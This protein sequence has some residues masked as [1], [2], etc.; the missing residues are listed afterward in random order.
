MTEKI[1][2]IMYKKEVK[3]IRLNAEELVAELKKYHSQG[4]KISAENNDIRFIDFDD[5]QENLGQLAGNPCI[6]IDDVTI[7]FHDELSYIYKHPKENNNL[8]MDTLNKIYLYINS[9]KSI[10]KYLFKFDLLIIF[11]VMIISFKIPIIENFY[12]YQLEN[13]K[14]IL[15]SMMFFHILIGIIVAYFSLKFQRKYS[16]VYFRPRDTFLSRNSDKIIMMILG[17][18]LGVVFTSIVQNL[19]L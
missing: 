15:I 7:Q 1:V 2:D 16:T 11:L 14:F 4:L 17:I 3:N 13:D 9:Y 8:N 19:L 12:K 10:L 18:V 5:M 6:E